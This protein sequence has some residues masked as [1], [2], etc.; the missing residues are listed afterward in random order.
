MW[1]TV[2]LPLKPEQ[3]PLL[4]LNVFPERKKG[5]DL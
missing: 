3:V 5:P 2:A 4:M 1:E